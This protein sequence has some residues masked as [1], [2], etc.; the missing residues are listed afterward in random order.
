MSQVM[1]SRMM[2][3]IGQMMLIRFMKVRKDGK[4]RLLK[5]LGL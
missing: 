2:C 1:Y 5:L 3:V 4:I